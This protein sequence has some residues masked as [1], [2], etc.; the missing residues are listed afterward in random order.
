MSF[1]GVYGETK[2]ETAPLNNV[3]LSTLISE[4]ANLFK[5]QTVQ[6]HMPPV[7]AHFAISQQLEWG[8]LLDLKHLINLTESPTYFACKFDRIIDF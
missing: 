6:T 1:N 5:I 2:R 8:P 7:L 4:W 3:Q